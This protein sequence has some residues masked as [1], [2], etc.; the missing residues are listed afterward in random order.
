VVSGI[1]INLIETYFSQLPPKGKKDTVT[2]DRERR[3]EREGQ[4]EDI[5]K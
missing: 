2:I 1:N 3:K 4:K 5:D